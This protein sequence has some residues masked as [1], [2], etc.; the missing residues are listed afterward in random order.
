[1]AQ[2]GRE[3]VEEGWREGGL[4]RREGVKDGGACE[5]TEATLC[6]LA[7]QDPARGAITSLP[8]SLPPVH[9]DAEKDALEAREEDE[10]TGRLPIALKRWGEEGGV[11]RLWHHV[12]R[13]RRNPRLGED[14]S[15]PLRGHPHLVWR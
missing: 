2:R 7:L 1:M 8:P 3:K 6:S 4:L 14:A 9:A 12:E 5:S 15:V 13:S 11:H 10:A